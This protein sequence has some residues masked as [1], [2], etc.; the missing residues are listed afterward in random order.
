MLVVGAADFM[1]SALGKIEYLREAQ[2]DEGCLRRLSMNYHPVDV[3]KVG[4]SY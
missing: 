2:T 3:I 4:V 1:V